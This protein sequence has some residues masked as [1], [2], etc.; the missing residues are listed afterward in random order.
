VKPY[1]TGE[2]NKAGFSDREKMV[3]QADSKCNLKRQI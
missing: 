2:G 1:A 3:I